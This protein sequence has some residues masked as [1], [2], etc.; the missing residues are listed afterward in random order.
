MKTINEKVE[1]LRTVLIAVFGQEGD[2]SICLSCPPG[3]LQSYRP[4]PDVSDLRAILARMEADRVAG[5]AFK[6]RYRTPIYEALLKIGFN[7]Q[8][9]E[10]LTDRTS[11]DCIRG[12]EFLEL[13]RS[14][15]S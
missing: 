13:V 11:R 3:C 12:D 1:Y 9:A 4:C 7:P 15:L 6:R 2:K 5:E 8:A 10:R 14:N